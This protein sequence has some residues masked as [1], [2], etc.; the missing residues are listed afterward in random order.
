MRAA[1]MFELSKFSE[2]EIIS[3]LSTDSLNK[4]HFF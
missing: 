3:K 2:I 1:E 4:K